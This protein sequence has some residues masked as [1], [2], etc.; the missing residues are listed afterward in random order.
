MQLARSLRALGADVE[1]VKR[2]GLQLMYASPVELQVDRIIVNLFRHIERSEIR[3]VVIDAV[4]EL[5]NATND[6]QRLHDYLYA[7]VQ[8]FTVR[9]VTCLL[10]FETTGGGPDSW[11]DANSVGGRFSYMSDNI[12]ILSTARRRLSVIKARAT[13]HDLGSH[14]VEITGQ[15]LRVRA[16][17]SALSQPGASTRSSLPTRSAGD[18]WS[19]NA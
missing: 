2:R 8:H 1:D 19:E 4:G 5:V 7:L 16:G 18:S 12:I 9:G 10:M 6:P 3:R 17:V 14:E 13:L 15:G 11:F